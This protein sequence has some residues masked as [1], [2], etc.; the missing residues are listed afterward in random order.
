MVTASEDNDILKQNKVKIVYISNV[1][2]DFPCFPKSF[3]IFSPLMSGLLRVHK[4]EIWTDYQ[5]T[6]WTIN[7]IK[8]IH[9]PTQK[10]SISYIAFLYR[11]NMN[12]N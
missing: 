8:I 3:P 5:T 2:L 9:R 1:W 10:Q 4:I 7:L 6:K 11:N 12:N